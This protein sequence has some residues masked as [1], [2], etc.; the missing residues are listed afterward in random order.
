MPS[1][2]CPGHGEFD[3]ED[4]DKNIRVRINA[5]P[6]SPT[7]RKRQ[8]TEAQLISN[9]TDFT[10]SL[11][12]DAVGLNDDKV[13]SGQPWT[14]FKDEDSGFKDDELC[15]D[16]CFWLKNNRSTLSSAWSEPEIQLFN[17]LVPVYIDIRRGPCF[18]AIAVEK[19]C[20]EVYSSRLRYSNTDGFPGIPEGFTVS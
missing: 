2:E 8:S 17:T 10:K 13:V 14:K 4:E 6:D 12:Q 16:H 15:S 9:G 11:V 7:I 1:H 19:P 5:K 3:D 18:I 20:F